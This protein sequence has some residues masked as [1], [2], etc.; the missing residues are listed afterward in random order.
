MNNDGLNEKQM[1]GQV[2]ELVKVGL[3]KP[4]ANRATIRW[5]TSRYT[6]KPPNASKKCA[7]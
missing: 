6:P 7:A 5:S 2:K 4:E 1:M 3:L